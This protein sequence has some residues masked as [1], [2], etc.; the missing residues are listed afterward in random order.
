VLCSTAREAGAQQNINSV[1]PGVGAQGVS[2]PIAR[3]G[4]GIRLGDFELHPGIA[5][6][7]GW[8]DNVF[9]EAPS[10]DPESSAVLRVSPHIHLSTL[11]AERLAE[12]V[13]E[14]DSQKVEFR[15]GA[16]GTFKQYFATELKDH[17][18]MGVGQD[19]RL[20]LRPGSVFQLEL[21]DEF[22]R[23]I[24]PFTQALAPTASGGTQPTAADYDR[25]QLGA[26]TRVQLSTPGRLFRV[27][28]GYR[29]DFDYFEGDTFAAN[30]NLSH[31]ISS[32]TSWE[33]LP[34]TALFWNGSIRLFKYTDDEAQAGSIVSRVDS[35]N[36][37]SRIGINGALT[38]RLGFTVAGGYGA[39][40]LQNNNDYE[41][42]IA[43][44]EARWKFRETAM[45]ALGYDREFN[46]S[47]QGNWARIDRIKTRL[48]ALLGGALI[49][50]LRAE[51]SWIDFGEDPVLME[52]RNDLHLLT[53]LMLEY[54]IVSWFAITGEVGYIQNFTDFVYTVS[55][56]TFMDPAKYHQFQAFF[57]V[58]AF[59]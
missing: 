8:T 29:F 3:E 9:L 49:T 39:G 43:Q 10:E 42:F 19:A 56:S 55:G 41:S 21:F 46:P 45:W 57:G 44:V 7:I 37:Q 18:N 47:F 4:H 58:R 5:T 28:A 20:T 35:T 17:P 52:G 53:D 15:F 2:S 1:T 32:D 34:K 31:T 50:T 6:E 59:L 22:H 11:T 36:I 25:D 51:L 16:T 27:G 33:F 54:R 38:P 13:G 12:N 40:F 30:R 26:G 24:D 23:T 48:Q 14:S